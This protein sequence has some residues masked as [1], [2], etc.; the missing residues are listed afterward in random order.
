MANYLPPEGFAPDQR[1]G[2]YYSQVITQDE[3]GNV[4]QVVTWFNPETGEYSRN[5]YPVNRQQAATPVQRTRPAAPPVNRQQ[6]TTPVQ[7]T[8]P[9]AP[10]VNRQQNSVAS[11]AKYKNYILAGIVGVAVIAAIIVAVRNIGGGSN[12]S[13]EDKFK[14]KTYYKSGEECYR[15]RD[16]EGA[17]EAFSEIVA[18][19]ENEETAYIGMANCYYDMGED[20]KAL[21][22]LKEGYDITESRKIKKTL[23]EL[24]E[25]L[26][27]ESAVADGNISVIKKP[28]AKGSDKDDSES[29]EASDS[30][31]SK[32]SD[33]DRELYADA[34]AA[35]F[36]FFD[37]LWPNYNNTTYS[38]PETDFPLY[39][40]Y[41][42]IAVYLEKPQENSVNSHFGSGYEITFNPY[43]FEVTT[44]VE[45]QSDFPNITNVGAITESNT[46]VQETEYRV[47]GNAV[48]C[49]T[50]TTEYYQL[51]YMLIPFTN[52]KGEHD[53]FAG[54]NMQ[55][56]TDISPVRDCAINAFA[57]MI[58]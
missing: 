20:E 46:L 52:S 47:N 7:R 24:E 1:T 40:R 4:F 51:Q 15:I 42:E 16:L 19:D 22:I 58:D 54:F 45:K 53:I 31:A 48:Y 29:F 28:A 35:D 10:S 30:G 49:V 39:D 57:N 26:G 12:L 18:L 38:G 8:R 50:T 44:R 9:V 55:M 6:T 33:K 56:E 41:G 2:L 27:T 37:M 13:K 34:P 14:I 3:N 36:A 25:L 23:K 5:V 17:L 21:S 43:N 11:L 32:A